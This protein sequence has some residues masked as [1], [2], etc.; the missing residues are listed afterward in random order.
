M[1]EFLWRSI[2]LGVAATALLDLWALF[3]NRAFGIAP[4]NW[5]M[6]GRWVGHLPS[7][8]LVHED[9]GK[10]AP[11]PNELA[12]GWVFHYV[13]G[14]VFAAAL[15]AIWGLGWARSPTLIPALIVGWVTIG[16][17]WFILQPA[18][19]AGIAAMKR[20]NAMQIR[21]LN[22]LGHT[23]FALGLYGAALLLRP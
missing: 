3:L 13:V 7:G 1:G 6:V 15:L 19:G 2:V 22:I 9:I 20:P 18:M 10:A 4:P 5:A 12:I 14:I 17:G 23:V 11:V 8:T 21:A 16:C